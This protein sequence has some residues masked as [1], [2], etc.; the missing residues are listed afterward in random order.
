M[1]KSK[2]YNY[3]QNDTNK[4]DKFWIKIENNKEGELVE[5]T[6]DITPIWNDKFGQGNN[7]TWGTDS[8]GN[9]YRRLYQNAFGG[10]A[11][12]GE[13]S[14][15]CNDVRYYKPD[16]ISVLIGANDAS[17]IDSPNNPYKLGTI[18]DVPVG[19]S[20]YY[21]LDKVYDK[22]KLASAI[23]NVEDRKIGMRVFFKK[24]DSSTDNVYY[25]GK[26]TD[27]EDWI[28]Q[29]NWVYWYQLSFYSFYKGCI[30]NIL[31]NNIWGTE[32]NVY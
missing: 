18:N 22:S 1:A 15:A 2:G 8:E 27:D 12:Y 20:N 28:N 29:S 4:S 13:C 17:G 3:N 5:A 23:T 9:Y 11:A 32:R 21:L 19:I 30:V 10:K 16:V 31:E 24:D 7:I 14:I 26:T 6:D 25:I